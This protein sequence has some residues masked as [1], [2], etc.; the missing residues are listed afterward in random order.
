ML[1][2][3]HI[4]VK[5][6]RSPDLQTR[7]PSCHVRYFITFLSIEYGN[8]VLQVMETCSKF[9]TPTH[10]TTHKA[11]DDWGYIS[12]ALPACQ[13]GVS[14]ILLTDLKALLTLLKKNS[15]R[16][17]HWRKPTNQS[18]MNCPAI[19]T[20]KSTYKTLKKTNKTIGRLDLFYPAK[21]SWT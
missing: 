9:N 15:W 13:F 4:P 19:W 12:Q 18:H 7:S 14:Y 10:P 17:R 16:I 5:D 8:Q 1:N 3:N 6:W 2:T 20:N 11:K 21:F